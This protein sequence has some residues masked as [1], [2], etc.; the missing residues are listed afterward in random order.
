[1]AKPKEFKS[2]SKVGLDIILGSCEPMQVRVLT[3]NTM[4]M[5]Y[6]NHQ[7]GTKMTS[8]AWMGIY[9]CLNRCLPVG[10]MQSEAMQQSGAH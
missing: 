7:E 2:K 5:F 8:D 1:M 6:I 4:V 3:A 10:P 9:I